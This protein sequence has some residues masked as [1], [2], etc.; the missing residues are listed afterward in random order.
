MTWVDGL[1]C[2]VL[3]ISVVAGALRG[4]TRE[5]FSVSAW[6]A[7]FWLAW[8]FGPRAGQTLGQ[9]LDAGLRLYLGYALVFIV[10]LLIGAIISSLLA[11]MVKAS[12][13]A[14]PDRTLGA[15]LGVLR[16]LILVV[17]ALML[18]SANG[19]RGSDWWQRSVIVPRLAPLADE[20]S[21]LVPAAWL[22]P[23]SAGNTPPSPASRTDG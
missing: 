10:I 11:R 3:V 16:G 6:V 2:A 18:A 20:M 7:A 12:P 4:F 9:H 14:G 17:A 5:V 1:I 19:E 15:A 23:L 22:K 21:T 13:L 8:R